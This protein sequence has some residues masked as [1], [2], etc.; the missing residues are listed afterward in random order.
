MVSEPIESCTLYVST[1][2]SM[3]YPLLIIAQ[4]DFF[5]GIGDIN[6]TFLPQQ[7]D[8]L[9]EVPTEQKNSSITTSA[10]PDSTPPIP[11]PS[12][13]ELANALSDQSTETAALDDSNKDN[14]AKTELITQNTLALEAQVEERPLA[15]K[16]ELLEEKEDENTCNS[17]GEAELNGAPSEPSDP[18][19]SK[20]H[21][22]A[23]LKNDDKDLTLICLVRYK[24]VLALSHRLYFYPTASR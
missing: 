10:T 6:S 1:T 22:N 14:A 12:S 8:P 7:V 17:T 5:V 19:R 23:L 18:V 21:R 24:Y 15:K 16:Q 20:H 3:R 9:K 13:P 4:D 2:F 11:V